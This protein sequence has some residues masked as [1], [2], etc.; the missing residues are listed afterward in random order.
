[1]QRVKIAF[2]DLEHWSEQ[3]GR[4]CGDMG[5]SFEEEPYTRVPIEE[6]N[7]TRSE[8][9]KYINSTDA[10]DNGECDKEDFSIY[11]IVTT[12]AYLDY[13]GEGLDTADIDRNKNKITD[14]YVCA[15]EEW[16]K[17]RIEKEFPYKGIVFHYRTDNGMFN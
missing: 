16:A 13:E 1:M 15:T 6:I 4:I 9:E 2:I 7:N 3:D 10:D 11:S 5:Y 8:L 17:S 14:V 12:D